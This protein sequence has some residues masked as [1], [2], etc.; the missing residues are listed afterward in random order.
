MAVHFQSCL[1]VFSFIG[2]FSR[3]TFWLIVAGKVQVLVT[4]PQ[5]N[6]INVYCDEMAA[7]AS[8]SK[9]QYI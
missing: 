9:T 7:M 5:N 3:Q 2:L 6:I 8:V 1:R 4:S